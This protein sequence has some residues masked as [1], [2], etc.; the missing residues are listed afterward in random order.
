MKIYEDEGHPMS[1]LVTLSVPNF[2]TG[3]ENMIEMVAC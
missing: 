1:K 2:P 3:K